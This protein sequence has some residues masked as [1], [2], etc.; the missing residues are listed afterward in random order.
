[1]QWTLDS[2]SAP[3]KCRF[4]DFA[5]N[6]L[7]RQLVNYLY[8]A[9]GSALGGLARLVVGVW[10]QE[11]LAD[12]LPHSGAKPFPIGTLIV[13]VSG[14]FVIGILIV[15]MAR[16]TE[17]SSLLYYLLTVGFCGGY[18]TFSTFSA[19]SVA[20]MESGGSNLAFL[21]IGASL[22]LALLGTFAGFALARSLV[23]RA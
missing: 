14:S 7:V 18:T 20:L 15:L 16:R 4:L 11:R 19:D 12:L 2:A 23:G 5:R 1:M 13:N 3:R 9:I 21:N 22:V 6:D 17:H 8:V 10:F